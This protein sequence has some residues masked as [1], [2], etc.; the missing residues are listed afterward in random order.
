MSEM[1]KL[2]L[3]TIKYHLFPLLKIVLLSTLMLVQA[4]VPDM[5][6][7]LRKWTQSETVSIRSTIRHQMKLASMGEN[8]NTP[9][10]T[11]NAN[12]PVGCVT[13]SFFEVI[14]YRRTLIMYTA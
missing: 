12:M 2:N 3:R 9:I 10:G 6:K 8:L 7:L 13:K 4:Q 5:W 14:I 11:H 1:L